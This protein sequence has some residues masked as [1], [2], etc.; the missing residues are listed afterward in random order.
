MMKVKNNTIHNPVCHVPQIL[1]NYGKKQKGKQ[2]IPGLNLYYLNHAI[3][4]FH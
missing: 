4:F 1:R 3:N 2:M